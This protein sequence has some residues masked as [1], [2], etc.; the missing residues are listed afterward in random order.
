MKTV[1]LISS[2]IHP[3]KTTR[4]EKDTGSFVYLSP[5][6]SVVLVSCRPCNR[7][8]QNIKASRTDLWRTYASSINNRHEI[9]I[10][11]IILNTVE[12]EMMIYLEPWRLKPSPP[13]GT[14][15]A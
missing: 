3:D 9:I 7:I 14:E 8:V 6:V 4:K 1:I 12:Q 2:Y 10:I 13:D 5:F 11:I 15:T